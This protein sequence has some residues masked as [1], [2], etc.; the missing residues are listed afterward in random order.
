[1]SEWLV[2]IVQLNK[3]GKHPN[4]DSLEIT[5]VY[6]RSVITRMGTFKRGDLAVFLPP[7]SIL[8]SEPEAKIIKAS[9]LKPGHCIDAIRLRGIF[10]N[11]M[12]LPVK[13]IFNENEVP[14]VGTH[15]AEMLGITKW[16]SPIDKLST[17]GEND[18]DL[19]YLPNYTDIEALPRYRNAFSE[20]VFGDVV[21]LEKI[22]GANYRCCVRNNELFVGSRTCWKRPSDNL[23]WNVA[24]Q[25]NIEERL[26]SLGE[27]AEH[28]G[29]FGEVF[30]QVQDLMYDVNG[31]TFRVFDIW[32][33]NLKKYLDW[34]EVV[35]IC[36]KLGIETVP[37][38]YKGP[39]SSDLEKLAEGKST[40]AKHVREGYVVKPV[41]EQYHNK[42]GRMILKHVGEGYKL[43]KKLK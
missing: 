33:S 39:W 31:A 10:S 40:L 38:L 9:G 17:G 23:W 29:L 30:G 14:P 7:D 24:K 26:K 27:I 18:K 20:N 35:D 21:I 42:I 22:H 1:M 32:D 34:N 36:S 6:G 13:E 8:P 41:I 28:I 37:V 5:E 16:E 11:G 15:V 4:A 19:G 2:H 43:R 12:I 25:M 3:I